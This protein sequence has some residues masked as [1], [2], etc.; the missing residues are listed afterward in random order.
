MKTLLVPTD[1]SVNANNALKYAI[2]FAKKE[3]DAKIILLHVFNVRDISPE[4]NPAF[5]PMAMDELQQKTEKMLRKLCE[6]IAKEGLKNNECLCKEGMVVDV[7]LD[8]VRKKNIDMVIMGTKGARGIKEIFI[9]SN[10][11]RV[12]EKAHCPVIIVP[13]KAGFKDIKN[14]TYVTDYYNSNISTM[15]QLVKVAKIFSAQI[16]VL[17]IYDEECM[18]SDEKD[19]MKNFI[20]KVKN[21]ISYKKISY[22]LIYGHYEE[23]LLVEYM[24]QTACDLLVV[25]RN[26]R[27]IFEKL[28]GKNITKKLA[29]HRSMPLM[30]F[31]DEPEVIPITKNMNILSSAFQLNFQPGVFVNFK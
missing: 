25:S 16:N 28:F 13:K 3:K 10:T 24:G 30:I 31:H 14:I 12:V 7:I 8:I 11:E 23:Q 1:F 2:A 18:A 9:G 5:I 27:P 19:F 4:L 17:N 6:K 15:S 29:Y 26:Y 20:Q 22:Q 21:K